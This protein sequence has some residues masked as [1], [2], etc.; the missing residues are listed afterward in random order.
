MRKH[1]GKHPICVEVFEDLDSKIK[2][3]LSQMIVVL[4]LLKIDF[5]NLHVS[6][7]IHKN[8]NLSENCACFDV[9]LGC[10]GYVYGL[11]VIKSFM[12]ENDLSKGLLF[13]SDPFKVIDES[14]KGTSLLFEMEQ[15]SHL[16]GK[17]L[18]SVFKI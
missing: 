15:L 12:N 13:T 8:L 7:I 1:W 6:S 11:S 5:K 10:S 14:D 16:L 3:N 9:S 18:N 4:L 17:N 2:I